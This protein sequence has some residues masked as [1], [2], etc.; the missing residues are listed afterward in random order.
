[1]YL[2]L[3][4][5]RFLGLLA[6]LQLFV[7]HGLVAQRNVNPQDLLNEADNLFRQRKIT[8]A[9]LKY[10][11]VLKYDKKNFYVITQ[12]AHCNSR[13]NKPEQAIRWYEQATI[14]DPSRDTLWFEYGLEQKKIGDYESSTI[15]FNKFLELHKRND[16]LLRQA[17]LEIEGNQFAVEQLAQPPKYNLEPTEIVGRGGEYDPTIFRDG[18]NRF[19]IFTSHRK[20]N[21]GPEDGYAETGEAYYSDLWAAEMTSD[22]TFGRAENLGNNVNTDANDGAA[23]ISPDNKTMYFT[24]CGEGKTGKNYGCSIYQ[25]AWDPEKKEW[26][27]YELVEGINGTIEMEAG[28]GGKKRKVATYDTHPTLTPD[29]NTMYFISDRPG[30]Q[31]SV[32]IWVSNRAGNVWSTP[33]NLGPTINTEFEELQ[34]YVGPDGSLYFASNGH[35]GM[36][37]YDLYKTTGSGTEWREPENLGYPLNS[38]Y[39]ELTL[40]WYYPDSTGLVSSNRPGGAGSD[41]IYYVRRIP[42]KVVRISVQGNVRDRSTRQ[43]IPFATVTLFEVND[44]KLT[45]VDTFRT[46]QQGRYQFSLKR[47]QE[48]KLVG[49]APEYLQSE[50]FISTR[51]IEESKRLERDIDIFLERIEISRPIVLQNIYFDFDKSD[52]RPES[53]TE[54]DK[55]VTLMLD[56]PGITIQID[57]HTDTN[58]SEDYN[59][60]LSNRRAK[61]AVEYLIEKGVAKERIRSFGYGESE[62]LVYPELSDNDEQANRRTEFRIRTLD[63]L[64]A[65]PSE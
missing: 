41:D 4:S 23:T 35:R 17:K 47:D 33:I 13:L 11:E 5:L 36:G 6:F 54:L 56:N 44:D 63:F 18:N 20:G 34:P 43:I 37:G 9:E 32:D 15:S 64:P 2:S 52:L 61:A 12:I 22:S 45:L 29:G 57:G 42:P 55:L 16:Y 8:D 58:G 30:G 25:S 40:L 21:L 26:G 59:I 50:E 46:D 39:D 1:M 27:P 49:T 14:L 10:R 38:S 7:A 31:G 24:I 53:I 28:R 19:L 65:Q 3:R 48:Y 62:P 60:G 51:G